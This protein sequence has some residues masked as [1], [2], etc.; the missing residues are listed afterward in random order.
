MTRQLIAWVVVVSAAVAPVAAA[1]PAPLAERIPSDAPA[2]FGWAGRSLVFDG[3]LL[4]Q[5]LGEPAVAQLLEAMRTALQKQ[6]GKDHMESDR[7]ATMRQLVGHAWEMGMTAW[8]HPAAAAVLDIPE[9]NAENALPPVAVLIDLGTDKADFEKQLNAALKALGEDIQTTTATIEGVEVKV[10][11]L[12]RAVTMC[13]GFQENLF[14]ATLGREAVEPILKVKPEESLATNKK[15][16]AVMKKV[17]G[18]NLQAAGYVDVTTVTARIAKL[19][20][21]AREGEPDLQ[22]VLKAAGL[23]KATAL[24]TA[25]RIMDRHMYTRTRLFSPAPHS[26]VPA[27]LG[28][29]PLKDADL[30]GVP[31]DADLFVVARLSLSTVLGESRKAASTILGDPNALDQGLE[32][33]RRQTGIDVRKDFADALGDT[34]VLSSAPSRGGFLTGTSLTVSLKDT[35]TATATVDKLETMLRQHSERMRQREDTHRWSR[36]TYPVLNIAKTARAD[37]RYL[38]F[39]GGW[40]PIAPAWCIYKDKLHVA[41]W[42]QVVKTILDNNGTARSVSA[43]EIYKAYRAKLSGKPVILSYVNTPSLLRQTYNMGLVVWT[44]GANTLT[45][46]TGVPFHAAWLPTLQ[47]LQK[48]MR[49]GITGVSLDDDGILVESYSAVPV[50][51]ELVSLPVMGASIAM[52][53]L[54]RARQE[55]QRAVSASRLQGV[56]NAMALYENQ[57]GRPASNYEVLIREGFMAVDQLDSPVDGSGELGWDSR[58]DVIRG[59]PDYILMNL[60]GKTDLPDKTIMAYEQPSH[61]RRKGTFVLYV[62][63]SV[64]WVDAET[65]E[66]QLAA[67][68]KAIGAK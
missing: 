5:M 53:S 46:E 49:P 32:M 43:D 22:K 3:S 45:D 4:G 16:L 41:L 27:L 37:I 12:D 19:L 51:A 60:A 8:Q 25:T 21:P 59:E 6:T 29:E 61:Y 34:W 52:P 1:N 48:Y 66:K 62:D 64:R 40:V 10:I 14:F 67:S 9:P 47:T 35:K 68:R 2:Y 31:V 42:P 13:L 56:G 30:S 39:R 57:Y 44:M 7:A 65:F 28:G 20:P 18:E 38:G 24:A 17:G 63:H 58:N 50:G 11:A 36:P 33:V 23:D 54:S 15:F 55:A 26:G